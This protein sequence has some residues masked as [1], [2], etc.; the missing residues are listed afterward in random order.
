M[1][2]FPYHEQGMLLPQ[3]RVSRAVYAI[4]QHL[5][6][7]PQYTTRYYYLTN[8]LHLKPQDYVSDG[9]EQT[10]YREAE[11]PEFYFVNGE[12]GQ[13]ISDGHNRVENV[14]DYVVSHRDN[15]LI[16]IFLRR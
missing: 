10:H 15:L 9:Y 14:F 5:W 11:T 2:D 1:G 8:D 6:Y 12:K 13:R 16:Q 4:V 7:S 3:Y